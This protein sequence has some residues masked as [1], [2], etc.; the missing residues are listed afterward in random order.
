LKLDAVI[1]GK[2]VLHIVNWYVLRRAGI[3]FTNDY[4]ARA[5]RDVVY[6]SVG[7]KPRLQVLHSR[8]LRYGIGILSLAQLSSASQLS[9]A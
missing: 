9:S 5:A 6:M 8:F 3:A 2:I 4:L 7:E 1:D